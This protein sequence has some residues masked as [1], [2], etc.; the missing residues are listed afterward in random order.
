MIE[1]DVCVVGAGIAGASVAARLAADRA[2]VLVEREALPGWHTTSRSAAIFTHVLPGAQVAP[3]T[4]ASEAFF[5]APPDGFSEAPLAQARPVLEF[6]DAG[7]FDALREMLDS[8]RAGGGAARW[9]DGPEACVM[10]PILRPEFAAGGVLD[11][12]AFEMDVDA[13]L[14]GFLRRLRGLGGQLL[15]GAPL[16]GVE[17]IGERWH[18]RAGETEVVA[19]VLVNAAG[20]WG[21]E[22]AGLAGARGLGLEPRRRT[23]TVMEL[24][25]DD[26]GRW[27]MCVQADHG[28]YFKPDAGRLL[29]SAMDQTPSPPCDAYADDMDVAEA[30]DRFAT[31]TTAPLRRPLRTWAG[32][33]TFAP[34][35]EPVAGFDP[36]VPGFFWLVGQGGAGIQTAPALSA[37]A[38]ALVRAE[39]L[40][41]ALTDFGVSEALLSP[42]RFRTP[43]AD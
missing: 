17:R 13:L 21:D 11:E 29:V 19:S 43:Q 39:P 18:V 14:Q 3:L 7:R 34:D 36:D 42:A 30:L 25:R 16:V 33:R 2:V 20:A 26:V 8:L 10:T 40:P 37:A 4:R 32:L 28:L 6:G 1:C 35:D 23:M 22:V 31:V 41:A 24:D 15:T 5:R 12:D 27:P 38:A 9:V